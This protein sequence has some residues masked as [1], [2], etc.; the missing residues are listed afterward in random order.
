MEIKLNK[1]SLENFMGIR[2]FSLDLNGRNAT[3]RGINGAGKTTIFSAFNYLLFGKDSQGRSDFAI[4]TLDKDG[5]EIHNLNHSVE[6]TLSIDGKE[7]VLK[8]VYAE[9]WTK[10]HGNPKADFTGHETQHFIDGVPIQK[11]EWDSRIKS[12]IEEET[13]K[14]LAS[15]T[16]FNS[17]HWTK[18]REILMQVCGDISDADV[19]ASDKDLSELPEILGQRTMEEQKKVLASKKKEIND[20]LK[21]IPSRIDELTKSLTNLPTEDRKSIEG[22]ISDLEGQIRVI[23]DDTVLPVLRKQKAE[24]EAN[25]SEARTALDKAKRN[26]A[27][28]FDQETERLESELRKKRSNLCDIG[29]DL[30][31]IAEKIQRNETEMAR[32]RGEFKEISNKKFAGE[33]IC[34]SCGQDLPEDQIKD[35]IENHNAQQATRLSDIN[36]QGKRLKEAN[37]KKANDKKVLEQKKED[38]EKEI[39]ALEAKISKNYANK[40]EAVKGTGKEESETI[41][42]LENEIEGVKMQIDAQQEEKTDTSPLESQIRAARAELAQIDGSNATEKRIVELGDEEKALAGEYEEIE[43]YIFLME[44]FIVQKVELLEHKINVRFELATFKLFS[45]NINGG[46]EECCTTLYDGVP[47]GYGLNT[48]AEINVGLDI[49]STLSAHYGVRA[50]IFID[51]AESV[52]NILDTGLQ[53]IKLAVDDCPTLEVSY[54]SGR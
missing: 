20:R 36:G 49:V 29:A 51:H 26:A 45:Q 16:Q 52:I 22:R 2:S 7:L 47:F 48:G 32:L 44:Q 17:L 31:R 37:Q 27:G 35:A 54:G 42:A 33:K 25:L 4:K 38:M 11:K 10:K 41:T 39:P 43:R 21:E 40:E 18:R 34:P 9:K 5:Q 12:I 1:L 6:G 50:P 3:V 19:I 14:L 23:S 46:I 28:D 53:T 24:L 13:F 8:K 30:E 15:P